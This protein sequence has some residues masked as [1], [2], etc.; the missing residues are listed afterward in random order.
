MLHSGQWTALVYARN[1]KHS[2]LVD[3]LENAMLHPTPS[4]NTVAQELLNPELDQA[5]A[6]GRCVELTA[7][8]SMRE[9]VLEAALI[10]MLL[11]V[12]LSPSALLSGIHYAR[13]HTHDLNGGTAR[14]DAALSLV[15]LSESS[16]MRMFLV[17]IGVVQILLDVMK[18]SLEQ[19]T[20]HQST[21]V[22]VDVT[23]PPSD[24]PSLACV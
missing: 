3:V 10:P 6:V 11:Q 18:D 16:E 15:R 22:L 2:V 12:A 5:A 4:Q 9:M 20:R 8:D 7:R 14:R 21:Q 19:H 17:E 1:Y 24:H 13:I 23:T